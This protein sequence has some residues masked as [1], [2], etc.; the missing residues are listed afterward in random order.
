MTNVRKCLKW[1]WTIDFGFNIISYFMGNP[2]SWVT[3][4]CAL[5]AIVLLYWTQDLN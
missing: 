1:L 4:L 2:P 3:S 5:G